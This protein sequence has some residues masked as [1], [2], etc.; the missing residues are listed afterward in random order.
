M[1]DNDQEVLSELRK[2]TRLLVLMAVTAETQTANIQVLSKVGFA[3]REI[4]ELLGTTSNTVNVALSQL[5]SKS[6]K[7]VP[8]RAQKQKG[9]QDD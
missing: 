6:K 1:N 9:P 3:P 8:A 7:S 5:R 4:A 2:I